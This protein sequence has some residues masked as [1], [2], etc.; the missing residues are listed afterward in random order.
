[1]SM[2]TIGLLGGMSWQSTAL[3]YDHINRMV[4]AS[5][6][7][8]HSARIAMVSVDFASI[9]AAQRAGR[10]DEAGGMLADGARALQRAG[11][12][13]VLICTNTMHLVAGQ[14]ADATDLPLIDIIDATGSALVA[15]GR[16]RPLLLATAYTMQHGFYQQRMSDRCGLEVTVPPAPSRARMHHIIFDELCRGTVS[17]ASRLEVQA[18]IGAGAQ[19]G[20]DSVILGCTEICMLIDGIGLTLPCFDSTR[21]HAEAAVAFALADEPPASL[22]LADERRAA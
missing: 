12:D 21:I 14:V 5:L 9:V 19:Q 17:D 13:C 11:A 20:A 2:K 10:W 1:M 8:L 7:G 4:E 15:S 3:Y 18:M 22:G 6:G 16:S